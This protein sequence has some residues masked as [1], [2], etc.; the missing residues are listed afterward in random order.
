[1][2][3][4]A[5]DVLEEALVSEDRRMAV[6]VAMKIAEYVLPKGVEQAVQLGNQASPEAQHEQQRIQ[7]L[8]QMTDMMINKA[9]R[10]D[11]PLPPDLEHAEAELKK[12]EEAESRLLNSKS[13]T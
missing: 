3:D 9:R 1:M 8:G 5:L 12:F 11:M 10:Y 2:G 4:K 13:S 7:M 6:A